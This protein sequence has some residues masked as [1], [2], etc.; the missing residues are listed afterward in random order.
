L[1]EQA[2]EVAPPLLQ[3][4]AA[5]REEARRLRGVVETV[6][7]RPYG[8]LPHVAYRWSFE[9]RLMG[10][11]SQY[12]TLG[13]GRSRVVRM[14]PW[15]TS[16]Q[17]IPTILAHELSH[18]FGFDE[19]LTVLRGLEASALLAEQGDPMHRVSVRLELVRLLLGAAM[20]DALRAGVDGE[21]DAFL[22]DR[23]DHPAMAR[24]RQQWQRVKGRQL[25]DWALTV[26]AEIPCASIETA[27]DLGRTESGRLAFPYFALDTFQAVA[28]AIYTAVD[29]LTRRRQQTV[30]LGATLRLWRSAGD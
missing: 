7:G 12:L 28:C 13:F 26:Y 16:R 20:G 3:D 17:S 4:D 29:A 18:R 25:P 21:V 5:L 1:L 30:P 23:G 15:E 27:A 24:P 22:Q 6:A 9:A 8:R 19:S 2:G 14:T 11:W 10:H